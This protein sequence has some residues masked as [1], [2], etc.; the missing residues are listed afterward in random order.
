MDA[1]IANL[2][3]LMIAR[4]DGVDHRFD[5]TDQRLDELTD[6]VKETNGRV[7][8]HDRQVAEQHARIEAID[9]DINRIVLAKVKGDD[10][11]DDKGENRRI[12]QRDVYLVLGTLGSAVAAIQILDW[13]GKLRVIAP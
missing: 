7:R 12:T 1:E 5:R 11:G 9:R 10:K 13:I 8:L 3:E 4:F 2:K 6:Q